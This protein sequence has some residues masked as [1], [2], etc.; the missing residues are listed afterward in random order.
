MAVQLNHTII[1]SRNAENSA[2][3]LSEFLNLSAPRSLGPFTIVQVGETSLDYVD[4]E[5]NIHPQHYAF[6]VSEAEF[7]EIFQRIQKSGK[8]YWADPHRLKEGEINTWDGGR[9]VYW[10]DPDG[11]LL[12]I[13]T[14]PYGSG[15]TTTTEPHP[16]L[17]NKKSGDD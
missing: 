8:T 16:L 7:D 15:G 6:L 13:I 9:G 11:H 2:R 10:D 14:C 17:A 4:T 3:F 12:E 5:E 1:S